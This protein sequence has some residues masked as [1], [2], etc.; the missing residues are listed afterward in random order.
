MARLRG[1]PGIGRVEGRPAP[2]VSACEAGDA[3]FN[4]S[5]LVIA[6]GV[7]YLKITNRPVSGCHVIGV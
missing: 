1:K 5:D 4:D 3:L 6:S 2:A 7:Y